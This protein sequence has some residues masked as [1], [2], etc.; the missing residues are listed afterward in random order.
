MARVIIIL[1]F[2]LLLSPLITAYS[3]DPVSCGNV[4]ANPDLTADII[5]TAVKEAL[6]IASYGAFRMTTNSGTPPD[7]AIVQALLGQSGRQHFIG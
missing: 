5:D 6:N 7:P 2:F 1:S 4:Q 3:I